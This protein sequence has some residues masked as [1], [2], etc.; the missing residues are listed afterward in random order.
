[1]L[2]GLGLGIPASPALFPKT[3]LQLAG[4]ALAPILLVAM[5]A[6]MQSSSDS[7]LLSAAA[8]TSHDLLGGARPA[9]S[10]AFV[11]LY[12][13]FGLAVALLMRDLI[14]TFRLGYTLFASGL[15]LPT[16]AA[17]VPR[18]RVTRGAAG[19]AMLLGGAA[20]MAERFF[21][22]LGIDP[23]LVGTGVNAATLAFGLRLVPRRAATPGARRG[24]GSS[25]RRSGSGASRRSRRHARPCRAW[26]PP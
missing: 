18:I 10:R 17:F 16:L 12:G 26:W 6:T 3:V 13:A 24:R 2:A 5:I 14:E 22:P 21:K 4:P 19:A 7:V 15:I 25:C 20:A 1:A 11:V 9:V 8:A 23:V